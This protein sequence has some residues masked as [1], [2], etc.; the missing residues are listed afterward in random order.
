MSDGKQF[1]LTPKY[2]K[3]CILL[4]FKCQPEIKLQ[5]KMMA[6]PTFSV[7]TRHGQGFYGMSPNVLNLLSE[8]SVW[9]SSLTLTVFIIFTST[10][11]IGLS[12]KSS[13]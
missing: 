5:D 1:C 4:F 2:P 8:I 7:P 9:F 13:M 6:E 11:S 10:E 3:K 12:L